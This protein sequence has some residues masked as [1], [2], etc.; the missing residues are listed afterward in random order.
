MARDKLRPCWSILM[1]TLAVIGRN[2]FL[3]LDEVGGDPEQQ[4]GIAWL[5]GGES[6]DGVGDGQRAAETADVAVSHQAGRHDRVEH[7]TELIAEIEGD[8]RDPHG[9]S[10]P[11]GRLA[12]QVGGNPS[13]ECGEHLAK[14]PTDAAVCTDKR[15]LRRH[16]CQVKIGQPLW[17][18][19]LLLEQHVAQGQG[20][21]RIVGVQPSH[22]PSVGFSFPS[23]DSVDV[24]PDP[25]I[26]RSDLL[27]AQ[28]LQRSAEGVAHG[29]TQ[30]APSDAV[31]SKLMRHR[32]SAPRMPVRTPDSPG[33]ILPDRTKR[34]ITAWSNDANRN[35]SPQPDNAVHDADMAPLALDPVAT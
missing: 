34:K 32:G 35:S 2:L 1:T 21:L 26:V 11:G 19:S 5:S 14:A 24:V 18:D 12:G 17:I 25:S 10:N 13:L 20:L 16:Q 6:A 22:P 8:R 33:R 9:R 28:P 29:G 30:Q 27:G 15:P 7:R 4:A 31:N 23:L 3:V